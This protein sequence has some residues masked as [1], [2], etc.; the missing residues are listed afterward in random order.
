MKKSKLISLCLLESR[1]KRLECW[2]DSKQIKTGW[3]VTL[4]NYV[5]PDRWWKIISKSAPRLSGEIKKSHDSKAIWEKDF[6]GKLKGL[7]YR[8]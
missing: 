8:S 6:R 7:D 1:N 2:L 5:E 4:K 3:S